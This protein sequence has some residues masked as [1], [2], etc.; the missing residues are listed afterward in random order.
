VYQEKGMSHD[1]AFHRLGTVRGYDN[2]DWNQDLMGRVL[3]LHAR[4]KMKVESGGYLRMDFVDLRIAIFAVRTTVRVKRQDAE[5]G[6]KW[7][8]KTKA[9][10][11]FDDKALL[12]LQQKTRTLIQSLELKLK[13]ANRTFEREHSRS[14][15]R[16]AASEWN[17]FLRWIRYHLAYFGKAPRDLGLRKYYQS[18]ID[19]IMEIARSVL[20]GAGYEMPSARDLRRAIRTFI[21]YSRRERSAWWD[22]S[23]LRH[24]PGDFA[25]RLRLLEFL[26]K[27]LNLQEN[28]RQCQEHAGS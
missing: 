8:E 26:E 28:E 4:I 17:R 7:D 16:R 9:K 2:G 25:P 11:G 6:R 18:A 22:F 21:R 13:R 12:R 5:L 3:D 15:F 1:Y 23:R 10:L 19:H 27:H 24:Y 14:E 20:L